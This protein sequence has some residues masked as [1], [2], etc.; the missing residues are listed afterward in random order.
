VLVSRI[1][2]KFP[3]ETIQ[4]I[5]KGNTVKTTKHND[6]SDSVDFDLERKSFEQ[7]IADGRRC[8]GKNMMNHRGIGLKIS[9]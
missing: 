9:K 8:H 3:E 2:D 4:A 7:T 6:P 5:R 1:Q